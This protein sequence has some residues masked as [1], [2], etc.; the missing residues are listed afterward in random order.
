MEAVRV[1]VVVGNCVFRF[2][3]RGSESCDYSCRGCGR[4]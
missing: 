4:L 3:G 1:V 2:G